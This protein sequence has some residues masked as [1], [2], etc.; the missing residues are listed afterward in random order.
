MAVQRTI[1]CLGRFTNSSSL[2]F[3]PTHPFFRELPLSSPLTIV[4]AAI[5][6]GRSRRR[7]WKRVRRH[8]RIS[9]GRILRF[10]ELGNEIFARRFKDP[11]TES[12][13]LGVPANGSRRDRVIR[14][15]S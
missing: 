14:N 3:P 10:F 7:I 6:R 15:W 5:Q 2:L 11:E 12:V 1:L 13:F 9:K 4:S 8:G